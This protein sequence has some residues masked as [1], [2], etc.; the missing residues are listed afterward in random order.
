MTQSPC[1]LGLKI[2]VDWIKIHEKNFQ[3]SV[4]A[5]KNQAITDIKEQQK[6]DLDTAVDLAKRFCSQVRALLFRVE[7]LSILSAIS[8]AWKYRTRP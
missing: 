8:V 3:H 6:R 5:D 4:I 7:F 2:T 1:S